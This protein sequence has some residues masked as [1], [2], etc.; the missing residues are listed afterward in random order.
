MLSAHYRSPLN[1]SADLME[2]SK[3]GL[4]RIVNAADNLKFLMGNAKA[5]AITDAEAENFAKT[6]EVCC[7]DLKRQWTMTSIQQMPLQQSLTL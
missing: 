7:Q 2:A 1:F 3:N 5:E 6:E 4:E